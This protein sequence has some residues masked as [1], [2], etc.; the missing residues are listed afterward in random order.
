LCF[1][2]FSFGKSVQRHENTRTNVHHQQYKQGERKKL[3]FYCWKMNAA[4]PHS[5]SD[6]SKE[7]EKNTRPIISTLLLIHQKQR[8]KYQF[9]TERRD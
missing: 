8:E 1:S 4:H 3:A 5:I 6:I 9:K 2:A 7:M